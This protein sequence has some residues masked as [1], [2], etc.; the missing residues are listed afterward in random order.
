[1]HV[2]H[3]N[4][5]NRKIRDKK[6]IYI[7][8]VSLGSKLNLYHFGLFCSSFYASMIYLYYFFLSYDKTTMG[9]IQMEPPSAAG[10]WTNSILLMETQAES[11]GDPGATHPA[12]ARTL[13]EREEMYVHLLT[14][15]EAVPFYMTHGR[16]GWWV[17]GG[18]W[19]EG[20]T[21]NRWGRTKNVFTL[22]WLSQ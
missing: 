8:F 13:S 21:M 6:I 5:F 1:M 7:Y 19:G 12:H 20:E 14:H 15:I 2:N 22:F 10:W 16:W 11:E 4:L 3:F 9:Q 18:R 17:R